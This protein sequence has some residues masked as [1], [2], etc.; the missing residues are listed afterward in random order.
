MMIPCRHLFACRL[1][2]NEK[3]FHHDDVAKRWRKDN[4]IAQLLANSDQPKSSG[5]NSAALSK[6]EKYNEA[7]KVCK[8]IA[9]FMSYFGMK[10]FQ[11]KLEVL[12]ILIGIWSSGKHALI[13]E[14]DEQCTT[15]SPFLTT[16]ECNMDHSI[17]TPAADF[18]DGMDIP[19]DELLSVYS[20]NSEVRIS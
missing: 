15:P 6:V 5:E 7:M 11:E 17:I 3:L 1:Q 13:V 20:V 9:D 10:E 8:N 14:H 2:N 19:D 12:N 4:N 16:S 18:T